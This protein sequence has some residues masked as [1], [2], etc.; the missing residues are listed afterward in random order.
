[1]LVF[2]LPGKLVGL[3]DREYAVLNTLHFTRNYICPRTILKDLYPTCL[4]SSVL[5][6]G[7]KALV[8]MDRLKLLVQNLDLSYRLEWVSERTVKL[9]QHSNDLGT[10]QL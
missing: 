2:K 1:M 8:E 5:Q 4:C 6:G 10:F 3:L 9:S 7:N